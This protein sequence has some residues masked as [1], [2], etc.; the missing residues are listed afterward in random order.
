MVRRGGVGR[1]VRSVARG[2]ERVVQPSTPARIAHRHRLLVRRDLRLERCGDA[3]CGSHDSAHSRR[4]AVWRRRTST[5]YS[6]MPGR[7]GPRPR[8][9]DERDSLRTGPRLPRER[10]ERFLPCRGCREHCPS[11][12]AWGTLA[13]GGRVTSESMW[14]LRLPLHRNPRSAP[15]RPVSPVLRS[16]VGRAA[17]ALWSVTPRPSA[18]G[19]FRRRAGSLQ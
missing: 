7:G 10:H 18:I 12:R 2:S 11:P 13:S 15:N 16:S 17:L 6:V 3:A 5:A 8:A 19:R 4:R 1:P 14:S 9:H